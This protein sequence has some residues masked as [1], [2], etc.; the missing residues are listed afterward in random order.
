M[1]AAQP[2]SRAQP[3]PTFST[4]VKVIAPAFLAYPPSH[5]G[6]IVHHYDFINTCNLLQEVMVDAMVL[7]SL[8]AGIMAETYRGIL[9]FCFY[10]YCPEEIKSFGFIFWGWEEAHC[11][12]A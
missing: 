5:L 8:K 7:A 12:S 6:T 3:L 11:F 2:T 9:S 10:L 1:E 4:K